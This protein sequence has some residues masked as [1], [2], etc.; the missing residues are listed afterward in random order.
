VARRCK[1]GPRH[2][3][4][5]PG[6]SVA[7]LLRYLGDQRRPNVGVLGPA[8][9]GP[10][11]PRAGFLLLLPNSACGWG[12]VHCG[13]GLLYI[14][15]LK[16]SRIL[17]WRSCSGV[18]ASLGRE[19]VVVPGEQAQRRR[20]TAVQSRDDFVTVFVMLH[21]QE[22]LI[23]NPDRSTCDA[24]KTNPGERERANRRARG[25]GCW[26]GYEAMPT[27][28]RPQ[29]KSRPCVESDACVVFRT[30][31]RLPILRSKV[32]LRELIVASGI[33]YLRKSIF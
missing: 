12:M 17:V 7:R 4:G 28:P 14:L 15:M 6:G 29:I 19:V 16:S 1:Q 25:H 32:C 27:P 9:L 20:P 26:E 11:V 21:L 18:L 10:A 8:T 2:E 23:G 5:A 24:S 33:L 31:C 13:G 3:K 22:V 30:A